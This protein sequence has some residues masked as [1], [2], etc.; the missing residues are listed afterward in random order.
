MNSQ[1]WLNEQNI[2]D[3]ECRNKNKFQVIQELKELLDKN[4]DKFVILTFYH[5]IF[6]DGL[7]NGYVQS[8]KYFLPP[9]IGL[10]RP[11]LGKLFSSSQDFAHPD[12]DFF[13]N[14]I[15]ESIKGYKNVIVC[16]A[17]EKSL[18]YFN[19][20]EQHFVVSGSASKTSPLPNKTNADYA[21]TENGIARLDFNENGSVELNFSL[22][23]QL[24]L[25]QALKLK[26]ALGKK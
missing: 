9:I 14:E 20:D 22:I 23:D 19:V 24:I 11:F 4:D 7:H 12:Y 21:A 15:L 5:S 1:W 13:R 6:S 16:S 2:N 26:T 18:Q 10:M 25:T 8:S 17:N 3:S